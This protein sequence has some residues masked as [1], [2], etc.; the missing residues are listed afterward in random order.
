M[1]DEAVPEAIFF[2]GVVYNTEAWPV[3]KGRGL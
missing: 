1:E 3:T 2:K